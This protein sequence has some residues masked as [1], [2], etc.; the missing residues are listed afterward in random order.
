MTNAET[1]QDIYQAFG[2]GDIPRI[3][4]YLSPS[5]EWEYGKISTDVPWLQPRRG[6]A[7]VAHFFAALQALEFHS[8]VPKHVLSSGN[9]VVSLVDVDVTVKA[10]GRRFLEEDEVH[11]WHFDSAGK[12]VRFRHRADTYLQQ[13]A[14]KPA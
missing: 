12:I 7:D 11:I 3:L 4:G 8:F 2:T 5:V 1:I 6:S 14:Y 10:T 9:I 13:L